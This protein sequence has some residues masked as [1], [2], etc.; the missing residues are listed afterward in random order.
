M[1]Q[2]GTRPSRRWGATAA[3]AYSAAITIP[4]RSTPPGGGDRGSGSSAPPDLCFDP[5]PWVGGD[6]RPVPQMPRTAPFRS[7]PPG[8]GR[9]VEAQA[10]PPPTLFRS[11][12]PGGGRR[13]VAV[14][15][16]APVSV[17]IHAPGWGATGEGSSEHRCGEGFRST[18]PGGGRPLI[19]D[20]ANMQ[21][22]FRSTPPGGGR[23]RCAG[24]ARQPQRFDPRPRVGGDLAAMS[25]SPM[26]S[27]FRSTPP[28]GGRPHDPWTVARLKAFRSTPPGGGRLQRA[29]VA[30][31][32]SP[33]SIHAP[34]WGATSRRTSP[35]RPKTS[36]DPRPR[37]GGDTCASGSR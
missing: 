15:L 12:P 13:D 35:C 19:T 30:L 6:G 5:R 14:G 16:L 24:T 11:T 10:A 33:V 29:F 23:R 4:F 3:E 31:V 8:G 9:R 25:S 18:P 37:V 36:F 28:G 22:M 1:Q 21:G 27:M 7:T 34:G 32:A 17:S 2:K 20:R 26:S